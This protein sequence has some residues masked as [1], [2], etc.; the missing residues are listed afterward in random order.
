MQIINTA[1][2]QM[3]ETHPRPSCYEA[4]AALRT[5]SF[6][7]G[8]V[9]RFGSIRSLFRLAGQRRT[10]S[11]ILLAGEVWRLLNNIGTQREIS[12]LLRLEPFSEAL[13]ISPRFLFKYLTPYYLALGLTVRQRSSCF[14]H[15]YRRLHKTVCVSAL[16]KM[17]N[18]SVTLHEVDYSGSKFAI[19]MGWVNSVLD[20]DMEGELSLDLQIDGEKI[21][22]LSF[23]FIPGWVMDQDYP[24]IMFVTRLQRSEERRVGK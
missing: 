23:T 20:K 22:N 11:P 6:D 13:Q 17:F 18:G 10:W 3:T 5:E 8:S 7:S 21:F 14:I 2:T 1:T 9:K 12:G 16:H 19:T 4:P 15:H 24:E